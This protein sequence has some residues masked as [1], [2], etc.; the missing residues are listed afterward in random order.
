MIFNVVVTPSPADGE[1]T[2]DSARFQAIMRH[3]HP[4]WSARVVNTVFLTPDVDGSIIELRYRTLF[5]THVSTL[6]ELN[7]ADRRALV[8]D[9]CGHSSHVDH[10]LVALGWSQNT[11]AGTMSSSFATC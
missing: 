11:N 2:I 8:R 6:N 4:E 7:A 5:A 10:V 9:L 1:P 3:R